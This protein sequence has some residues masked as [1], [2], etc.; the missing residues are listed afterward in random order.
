[1]F[2]ELSF[3]P[4]DVVSTTQ[5]LSFMILRILKRRLYLLIKRK[6]FS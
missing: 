5:W 1:M 3:P 2:V 6:D 4:T